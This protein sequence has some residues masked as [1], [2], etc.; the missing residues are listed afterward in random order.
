MACEKRLTTPP[1]ERARSPTATKLNS[2]T[3]PE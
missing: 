1:L 3:P 2:A